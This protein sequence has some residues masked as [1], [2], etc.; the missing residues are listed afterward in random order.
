MNVSEHVQTLK[1]FADSFLSGH[2]ETDYHIGLKLDH[3]LRVFDNARSIVNAEDL[4]RCEA[5]TA[6]LGA[7]YH[8]IGRFPQFARYKTYKDGDSINH[9]RQGV[10]TLRELDMASRYPAFDWRMIRAT[11]GMHNVKSIRMQLPQPLDK[12][13]RVVRDADKLDIFNVIVS[14]MDGTDELHSTVTHGT[15]NDPDKYSSAVYEAAMNKD[16]GD[17]TLIKFTNDFKILILGWAFHLNFRASRTALL[18]GGHLE[19]LFDS[20]PDDSKIMCFKEKVFNFLH[21]NSL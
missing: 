4:N 18:E 20:L 8:D 9:G 5:E 19:A 17:Y 2:D 10:L 6:L 11:V 16:D 7:I 1:T 15:C 12:A 14:H 21:D 13:I 3:S